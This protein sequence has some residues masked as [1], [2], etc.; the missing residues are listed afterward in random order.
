MIR[1][2]GLVQCSNCFLNATAAGGQRESC[3]LQQN[4]PFTISVTPIWYMDADWLFTVCC[5]TLAAANYVAETQLRRS[6]KV[7]GS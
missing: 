2:I 7:G 3:G 5:Q 4:L 6:R 1:F